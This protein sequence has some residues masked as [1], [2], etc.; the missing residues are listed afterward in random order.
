[1]GSVYNA[2]GLEV[3]DSVP[4]AVPIG[5]RRPESLSEQIKRMVRQEV[6]E[7]ARSHGRETFEEACDFG[8]EEDTDDF[9]TPYEVQGMRDEVPSG[10]EGLLVD[11]GSG[12]VGA[13]GDGGD[14]GEDERSGVGAGKRDAVEGAGE[15]QRSAPKG[16]E[17]VVAPASGPVAGKAG[18]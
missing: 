8:E 3:P 6:S 17:N 9:L 7:H 5:A 15:D 12:R 11:R 14:V 16:A 2:E 10:D 18:A 1:M 13:A 4:C